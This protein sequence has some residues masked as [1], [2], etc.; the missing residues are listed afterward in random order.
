MERSWVT[1]SIAAEIFEGV[2]EIVGA[3]FDVQQLWNVGMSYNK[4]VIQI[5]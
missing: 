3:V 5:I 1:C 4:H 2:V